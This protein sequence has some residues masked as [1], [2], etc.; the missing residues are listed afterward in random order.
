MPHFYLIYKLKQNW[1]YGKF[2][3]ESDM[4]SDLLE[5]IL[6][7]GLEFERLYSQQ[8]Q[9][10]GQVPIPSTSPLHCTVSSDLWPLL[11][12]STLGGP[13]SSL[14]APHPHRAGPTPLPSSAAKDTCSHMWLEKQKTKTLQPY[15]QHIGQLRNIF[16]AITQ[17]MIYDSDC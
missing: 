15:I 9:N 6:N 10:P 2:K 4:S 13:R 11:S 16:S 5:N 14:H 7:V 3:K 12:P 8:S 1:G 17:R